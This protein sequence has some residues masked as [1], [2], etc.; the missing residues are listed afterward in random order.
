LNLR[1]ALIVS[2]SLALTGCL[3]GPD[4]EPPPSSAPNAW[5]APLASGLSAEAPTEDEIARWWEALGDPLLVE[6]E[7]RA[8]AANRDI[9]S[10]Q[11]RLREARARRSGARAGLF[12]NS[13]GGATASQSDGS[14]ALS[15]GIN[16]G[17]RELYDVSFDASWEI[18]LFGGLRRGL[19]AAKADLAA[20]AA[21]LA[22]VRVSVAAEVADAYVTLRAQQQRLA[23]A[24]E[25]ARAQAETLALTRWRS[26]AGLTTELDV[27]QA[28]ANLA[29][30]QAAIP[31][32]R[33]AVALNETRLAVLVG[34]PPGALAQQ[35]AAPAKVPAPPERI[36][37]GVPAAA[38]A[39]RPDVRAAERQLAA[40]T[41]RIGVAKASALPRLTLTGSVGVESL[42]TGDLFTSAAKTT[43]VAAGLSQVLLDF[44][45]VKAQIDAQKAVRDRALAELEGTLLGALKEVED[46]LVAFAQEEARRD[47]LAEAANAAQRAAALSRDQYA[48][49]LVDFEAVLAAER[50]LFTSQ[51]QLAASEG[52]FAANLVRVYKALGGGWQNEESL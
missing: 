44:G 6:L 50:A 23:L 28:R 8:A 12:P 5:R 3:V 7:Q 1:R 43:S 20:S 9:A 32:L 35:L 31:Q 45:R 4:F 38:L 46:A 13:R 47:A 33:T 40:E 24:E 51:D 21:N 29:Q 30:T 11:A 52:E 42:T 36:A 34:E 17:A 2:A 19:E 15:A 37:V 16:L 41:A 25:N 49:G 18:D 27:E 48:A 14:G 22:G 39:R 10:A 26:A